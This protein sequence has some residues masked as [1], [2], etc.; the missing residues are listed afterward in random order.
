MTQPRPSRD[1]QNALRLYDA[2]TTIL[3]HGPMYSDAS[4]RMTI[5]WLEEG[6]DE[7]E[8]DPD[9][10]KMRQHLIDAFKLCLGYDG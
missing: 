8:L 3:A 9:E 2:A 7:I 5:A 4:V 6:I 10:K 1:V